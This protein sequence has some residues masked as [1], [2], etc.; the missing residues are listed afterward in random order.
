MVK[1]NQKVTRTM[2]FKQKAKLEMRQVLKDLALEH[3]GRNLK[4]REKNHHLL[5][6]LRL[7]GWEITQDTLFDTARHLGF[8][9]IGICIYDEGD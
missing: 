8:T 5:N 4:T 2:S 7:Y 1:F 9:V 3:E 6:R